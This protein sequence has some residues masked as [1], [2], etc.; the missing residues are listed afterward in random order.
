MTVFFDLI[1]SNIGARYVAFAFLVIHRGIDLL[2]LIMKL[3][4]GGTALGQRI[5]DQ[6]ESELKQSEVQKQLFMNNLNVTSEENKAYAEA[7]NQAYQCDEIKK[8]MKSHAIELTQLTLPINNAID[9]MQRIKEFEIKM[10]QT[11]IETPELKQVAYS[12]WF[13]AVN[14]VHDHIQKFSAKVKQP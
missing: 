11:Q 7:S 1:K 4:S 5:S 9:A 3:I 6:K 12:L 8:S 10:Q 14:K 13:E 2:P